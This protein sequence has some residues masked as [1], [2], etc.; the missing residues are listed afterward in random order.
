MHIPLAYGK[1]PKTTIATF[2]HRGTMFFHTSPILHPVDIGVCPNLRVSKMSESTK[3]YKRAHWCPDP[4]GFRCQNFDPPKTP[5]P[6]DRD[7]SDGG[8]WNGYAERHD[9]ENMWKNFAW[10]SSQTMGYS[11][12]YHDIPQ[13]SWFCHVLSSCSPS[14]RPNFWLYNGTHWRCTFQ[15]PSFLVPNIRSVGWVF[16]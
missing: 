9:F 4:H 5:F 15:R 3:K 8:T 7:R 2:K 14:K 10:K 11:M 13:I 12:I 1:C 6:W 16:Y